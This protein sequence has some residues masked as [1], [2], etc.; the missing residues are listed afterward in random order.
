MP[1]LYFP[2]LDV[3]KLV[4]QSQALPG[5]MQVS[6]CTAII[7]AKQDLFV[8]N[9]QPLSAD[10]LAALK[11]FGVNVVENVE[12]TTDQPCEIINASCWFQLL[13]LQKCQTDDHDL[14]KT[15]IFRTGSPEKFTAL[16]S[17]MLR[18]G[19][20]RIGY[21]QVE[22][23]TAEE[24]YTLI[25]VIEPPYYTL[26][27]V[28]DA[29]QAGA[30]RDVAAYREQAPRV[31]VRM[32]YQHPLAGRIDPPV[33][34]LLIVDPP[35]EF[36]FVEEAA[37]LDIYQTLDVRLPQPALA[38]Q[39]AAVTTRLPVPLTLT[40][41][42]SATA[43]ELWVVRNNAMQQ[44]E[45]LVARSDDELIERLAF[46]VVP[47]EA[48]PTVVL[49]VRPSR[50]APPVLILDA[51]AYC[52]TMRLPN[53]FVPVGMR[54]QPPLRR[55]AIA[56]LLASDNRVLTW[57]ESAESTDPSRRFLPFQ[58]Q[59]IADA[60][61]RPLG[62]WVEYVL[63]HHA[64]ALDTWT[65]SHRFE[66]GSF[67][68]KE[69]V[70]EP[71]EPT[72]G[73]PSS[74]A[75]AGI[76]QADKQT[77]V[78]VEKGQTTSERP[79]LIQLVEEP[80]RVSTN[81]FIEQLKQVEAEFVKS[82]DPLDAPSRIQQWLRLGQLHAHLKHQLDA[83]ICWSNLLWYSGHVTTE[84]VEQ[85][86]QAE[87]RSS[88]RNR[89]DLNAVRSLVSQSDCR[90]KDASLVAAYV[91]RAV[92]DSHEHTHLRALAPAI[93]QYFER[94]EDYLPVRVVWLTALAMHKLVGGDPLGLARVRDRLL[95]R[96]YEH[97]LMG[98]FD[99]VSFLR[100]GS[101]NQSDQHRA[102]RARWRELLAA[103]NNWLA[104]P[105]M[106]KNQT[107]VYVKLIF[108]YCL[109]RMGEV[110]HGRELLHQAT[111][112]LDSAE[113]IHLWMGMAFNF[114]VDQAAQGANNRETLPDDLVRQLE[115]MEPLDR[116]KIDRLRSHS[117]VLE[118]HERIDPYRHWHR[119]YTDELF[120]TLAEL[121]DL[122]DLKKVETRL[123][124]LLAEHTQGVRGLRVLATALEYAPRLG[125]EFATQF[126]ERVDDLLGEGTD[127][128][129]K[130]LLLH[131]AIYVAAH[132]GHTPRVNSLVTRL[133]DELPAIVDNYLQL[134][135]QYNPVDKE[136]IET[137]E[138]L[139]QHS[140]RGLRKLGMRNELSALYGRIAE[141]VD[142]HEQHSKS[143]RRGAALPNDPSLA[144][145]LSLLLSVA[146]GYY[147]FGNNADADSTAEKVRQVLL[148]GA[149]PTVEQRR[150]A[151]GYVHCISL[152]NPDLAVQRMF[153][154]FKRLA[155]GQRLLPKIEDTMT[156]CSHFSISE[157]EF[158]E[159]CLLSL[160]SDESK[161]DPQ[162]QLWLDQDE[163]A[164]RK[165]IHAEMRSA[166]M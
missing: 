99:I 3:L 150:L 29:T 52:T 36:H 139:L 25:R 133:G 47:N 49:R 138:S 70:R 75:S 152:G 82:P 123:R 115:F 136:R 26:I 8:E 101:Q 19:N 88:G 97:G 14:P 1:Y 17:E 161:W 143:S 121:K 6:P 155:D 13:P 132:F 57:L 74:N 125:D 130:A 67:V 142:K 79:T 89:I 86:L 147:Y 119:R 92:V 4:L 20:D 98:E 53:L 164:I 69:D 60:A 64:K 65:A 22:T 72:P 32:G 21:R 76:A 95:E 113:L 126:L 149:L 68:C 159:A 128:I 73:A 46:A 45:Q 160:L 9:S 63:D 66:F 31:W 146:S 41:T 131:R 55:D 15:I 56:K 162:S 107:H 54:I 110:V 153:E 96:L 137:V 43:A 87:L 16:A 80:R 42:G 163:F 156:T 116:Y 51:T 10:G 117:R 105:M 93:T 28:L 59:S 112:E 114:R 120:Q 145:R 18:L 81:E 27:D 33:G 7:T 48:E 154:L 103:V 127:V 62:D 5:S 71:P 37:F 157:L 166:L 84:F 102:L 94:Q 35:H 58:A 50:A 135:N 165:K 34:C 2:S 91:Q 111:E 151:I 85:W 23:E 39:S 141:L 77:E 78:E 106:P 12:P 104:L 44:L 124:A 109:A 83:T 118:P 140:F 100:G 129:E 134:E 30:G 148:E 122:L 108:A 90:G 61:F 144:R 24:S 158:V 11:A 38:W 40:A